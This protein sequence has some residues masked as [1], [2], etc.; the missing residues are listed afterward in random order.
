MILR[1]ESGQMELNEIQ[2]LAGPILMKKTDDL[3]KEY[4]RYRFRGVQ[5]ALERANNSENADTYTLRKEMN[6]WKELL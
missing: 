2:L 4:F 1:A 5:L 6:I 3:T